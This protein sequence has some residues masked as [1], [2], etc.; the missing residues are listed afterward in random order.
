MEK[1]QQ[2]MSLLGLRVRDC[3]TG[4]EGTVSSVNFDLY[5]CIQAC[6][7]PPIGNDGKKGDGHWFDVSRLDVKDPT[8]VMSRP[9]YV[10]GPVA[11]GR[12]GAA[13]KPLPPGA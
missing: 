11:E 7:V 10:S 13:E 5:G 9:D 4:F 8:P 1:V 6:V 2:H 3:V 12:H